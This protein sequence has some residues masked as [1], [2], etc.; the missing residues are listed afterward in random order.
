[1]IKGNYAWAKGYPKE[2]QIQW[3]HNKPKT[4]GQTRMQ[5]KLKTTYKRIEL[6]LP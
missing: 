2:P 4:T 6:W 5:G 1:M 3:L